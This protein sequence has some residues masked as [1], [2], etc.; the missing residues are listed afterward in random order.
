MIIF[1]FDNVYLRWGLLALKSLQLHEP[2]QQVLCDTVNL[3]R[4]QIDE[5]HQAHQ[6]LI[7]VNHAVTETS[8][9]QMAARK[10]YVMQ[11]VMDSYPDQPWYGLFDA[12]FLIRKPLSELWGLLDSHPAAL[13]MTNGM[14]DGKYYKKLITPSGLVLV[15]PQARKLV[16]C[17]ARWCSHDQ[18]LESIEPGAW[19]WDQIALAE[20]WEEAG[21][22]CAVIPMN[23]YADNELWKSTSIWSA[24]VPQKEKYY[25]LF[26][27]EYRRQY[28]E[29]S[30]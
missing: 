24:H 20:A 4:L 17:W 1:Q 15:R 22:P 10:P 14:W 6:R 3:T 9:G 13:Y 7:V 23:I 19:F 28:Q 29:T 11:R 30:N 5:L 18:P 25:E 8:P 12:D 16:D 21:V 27:L 26:S 2:D